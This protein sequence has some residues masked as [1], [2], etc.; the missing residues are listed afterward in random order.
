V[1]HFLLLGSSVVHIPPPLQKDLSA[2]R[3]ARAVVEPYITMHEKSSG[4]VEAEKVA[5][6]ALEV[7]K[8]L[9]SPDI[10]VNGAESPR[11]LVLE[12]AIT[13]MVP[14]SSLVQILLASL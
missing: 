9:P 10:L 8:E 12:E 5:A 1:V 11:P 14:V 3:V 2:L 6:M 7:A 4:V 13:V